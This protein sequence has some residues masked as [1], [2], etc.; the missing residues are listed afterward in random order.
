MS[1]AMFHANK[2]KKDCISYKTTAGGSTCAGLDKL[3]CGLGDGKCSFYKKATCEYC[4][5]CIPIGDGDHVYDERDMP[6]V[7]ISG[8]NPTED[9]FHCKGRKFK[10]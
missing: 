5:N 7:V 10:N 4:S 2:V 6:K 8:Y 3:Y 1:K 9:Y